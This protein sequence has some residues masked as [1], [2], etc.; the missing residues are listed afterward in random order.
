MIFKLISSD[1]YGIPV[2]LL[3]SL[4]IFNKGSN[5]TP[6]ELVYCTHWRPS[7][8]YQIPLHPWNYCTHKKGWNREFGKGVSK[9]LTALANRKTIFDHKQNHIIIYI[10]VDTIILYGNYHGF[11]SA[12][13]RHELHSRQ[14]ET[15]GRT[16]SV[17]T[18]DIHRYT[19]I[20]M[21]IDYNDSIDGIGVHDGIQ[22]RYR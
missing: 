10:Y 4:K 6:E 13:R 17:I 15:P 18:W 14:T 20:Y 21:Q 1:Q 3:H 2:A 7:I 8:R 22:V 12:S 5:P 11:G 9:T 16:V 19:W